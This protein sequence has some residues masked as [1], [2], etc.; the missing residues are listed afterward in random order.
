MTWY[1]TAPSGT[2]LTLNI[3]G[4]VGRVGWEE[5]RGDVS[6]VLDN[7]VVLAIQQNPVSSESPITG[8][9]LTWDG[10]RWSPQPVAVSGHDILSLSHSD[11]VID[12]VTRGDLLAVTAASKWARKPIGESGKVLGN[13]GLDPDWVEHCIFTPLIVTAGAS[14]DLTSSS[15]KVIINKSIAGITTVNLPVTPKVGQEVLVKDGKGD[16]KA[17]NITILAPGKTIDGL[18]S[19]VMINNYQ[20]YSML[21]NGTEWNIV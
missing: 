18:S 13:D 19:V 9:A 8:Y 12:S 20:A 17:N 10:T 2:V 16:A 11:S 14:V 7:L 6:G 1:G 4:G 21:Y 3:G 5:A 15:R